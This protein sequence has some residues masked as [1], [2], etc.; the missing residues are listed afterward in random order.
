MLAAERMM[1]DKATAVS[2]VAQDVIKATPW[3]DENARTPSSTF[4]ENAGKAAAEEGVKR[5]AKAVASQTA[6]W[7]FF[8]SDCPYCKA[9][10]PR[11]SSFRRLMAIESLPFLWTAAIFQA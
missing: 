9:Q 3:L 8:K 2:T 5:W 10:V 4:G 1:R 11:F 6:I 7:F